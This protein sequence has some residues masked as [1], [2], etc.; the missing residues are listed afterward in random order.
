M[1]AGP[2]VRRGASRPQ[3]VVSVVRQLNGLIEPSLGLTT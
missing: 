3:Y 2:H 1:D